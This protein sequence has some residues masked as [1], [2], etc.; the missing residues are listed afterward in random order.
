MN[1]GKYSLARKISFQ[2]LQFILSIAQKLFG[3]TQNKL[4]YYKFF[5][6]NKCFLIHFDKI[7]GGLHCRRSF[8]VGFRSFYLT[9]VDGMQLNMSNAKCCDV[10][11]LTRRQKLIFSMQIPVYCRLY[12][13]RQLSA[14]RLN[15]I[16]I[17][18]INIDDDLRLKCI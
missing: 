6:F 1:I 10:W 11:V 14:Y 3:Q 5:F 12:T 7:I 4:P 2:N 17:L 13:D 16:E 9:P 18:M 15:Q 8:S